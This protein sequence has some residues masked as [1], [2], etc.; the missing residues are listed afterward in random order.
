MELKMS[1]FF[2]VIREMIK[3]EGLQYDF[4][5]DLNGTENENRISEN[6]PSKPG[7]NSK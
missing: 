1:E 6:T 2:D 5:V 3:E 4:A 7:I